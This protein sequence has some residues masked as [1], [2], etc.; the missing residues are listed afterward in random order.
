MGL[1]QVAHRRDLEKGQMVEVAIE[2][3]KIVLVEYQGRVKAF[4]GDCPHE[5]AALAQGHIESDHIVCPLHRRNFSCRDGKHNLS[6]QCL[7]SYAV[8]EKDDAI[9][10]DNNGISKEEKGNSNYPLKNINSLPSPKGSL[11]LGHLLQFKSKSNHLVLEEWT[12]EVGSLFKIN[13]GGKKFI[14]SADNDINRQ[15]LKSRPHHFGRFSKIREIMEEMGVVG[16]FNAEGKTWERHRKLTAEALNFKNT[17]SYLPTILLMTKRLLQRWSNFSE[18]GREIDVQKE[19]MR[20]TVDITTTV[21]FGYDTHT[22][23]R[24]GDILQQHLEKVFPMIN[25]RMTAPIPYWKFIKFKKDKELDA[26]L[27]EIKKT[28][29]DFILSAR[30]RMKEQP[31]LRANP[32]NFLEALLVEQ[33]KDGH[34]TDKEVFGNVFT[35]LLAGEDTTSNSISWIIYYLA[36]HP[37]ILNEIRNEVDRVIGDKAFPD[38]FEE[39]NDLK[40]TE[41]VVLEAIRLKPVAPVIFLEALTDTV[42]NGLEIK[43]GTGLI[44]QNKVAHTEAKNFAQP[45]EFVPERWLSGKC[46]FSGA[47]KPEVIQAFG[48][49]PRYCPGKNLAMFE[50]VVATAMI[51]KNFD[52][53]F[54][55]KPD[56]VEEI[57]SFT[58]YPQNLIVSLKKILIE[59]I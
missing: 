22:L 9:F 48:N 47:Y 42:V 29:D 33:E 59:Q 34:F 53:E 58:M 45:E 26:A 28:I 6:D 1:T 23:E 12:K 32:S 27:S 3:K 21:A 25:K 36:K 57:F 18:E 11:L 39:I 16:T 24:D 55:V 44:L 38:S 17:K 52:L 50:M 46:P 43:N 8:V 49:G 51:C 4:Q 56:E 54:A 15:V 31:S 7:K 41:A 13:L 30:Q 10:I 35:I 2:G 19:L 20:Y 37:R 14:V 5:G 40:Y